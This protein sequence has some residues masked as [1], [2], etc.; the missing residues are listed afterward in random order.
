[1]KFFSARNIFLVFILLCA[2]GLAGR[3]LFS[4]NKGVESGDATVE[5]DRDSIEYKVSHEILDGVDYTHKPCGQITYCDPDYLSASLDSVYTSTKLGVQFSYIDRYVKKI[6]EQ[7]NEIYI[8]G[9]HAI[10]VGDE[11]YHYTHHLADITVFSKEIDETLEEA[12]RRVVFEGK[13][14]SCEIRSSTY[15]K[16]E[17]LELNLQNV[18]RTDEQSY[19]KFREE[20]KISTLPSSSYFVSQKGWGK[21]FLID[22]RQDHPIFAPDSLRPFSD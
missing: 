15:F 14:M 17:Y 10:P 12:V 18:L 13:K 8:I 22:T 21:F 6:V 3:F 2:L 11:E 4:V 16:K 7:G 20:C 19:E 9:D 1:M 5:T